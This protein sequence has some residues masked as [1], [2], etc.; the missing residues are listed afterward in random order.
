[1]SV[2]AAT[3]TLVGSTP[4][5]FIRSETPWTVATT[6]GPTGSSAV[7]PQETTTFA[8]SIGTPFFSA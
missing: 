3:C 6:S 8:T 4:T 1:V 2:F 7:A 5:E